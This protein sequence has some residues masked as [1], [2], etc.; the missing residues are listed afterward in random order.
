MKIGFI[1][2]GQGSQYVGMG[3]E[4]YE[5]FQSFRSICERANE[6]LDFDITN[7]MF[8][9]EKEQLNITENTQPA[10]LTMSAGILSILKEKGIEAEAVAGLSLGEYSALYASSAIDFE[11]CV[12]LVKKRGHYMQEAVPLGV[13]GMAAIIGLSEEKL[14]E[15]L[16]EARKYGVV[17]ISNYNT[18]KQLV[19]GGEAKAVEVAIELCKEAGAR[20]AVPLKVSGPFHTPL[21]EEASVNLA[22]ELNN[23]EFQDMKIPVL[24]NVTAEVIADSSQI[25]DLLIKQVKSSVKWTET[26]RNMIDMG[27]DT[28]IEIGPSRTLSGFL[29]DI[30]RSVT[31]FNVEDMKSLNKTLEGILIK[32]A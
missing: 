15:C 3:K 30:Y 12:K 32:N 21:L 14:K 31:T 20:R 19:I 26:I 5:N 1:F 13:G 24:T 6:A 27:I 17:E 4:L 11:T 23:I 10:I 8:D 7:L 2:S 16:V 29:R 22:K 28:F 18:P 25:K 9:G